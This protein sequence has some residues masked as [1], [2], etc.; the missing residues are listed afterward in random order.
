[1]DILV[2]LFAWMA[3]FAHSPVETFIALLKNISFMIPM[4]GGG[5]LCA[6][7]YEGVEEKVIPIYYRIRYGIAEPPEWTNRNDDDLWKKMVGDKVVKA[8]KVILVIFCV[9][10]FVT[11]F[12]LWSMLLV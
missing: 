12:F 4:V 10:L 2:A 7:I 6:F 11:M 5:L 3:S 1:M 8:F 9:V